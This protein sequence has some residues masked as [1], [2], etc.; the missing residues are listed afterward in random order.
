MILESI[1]IRTPCCKRLAMRTV[2]TVLHLGDGMSAKVSANLAQQTVCP[3][4]GSTVAWDEG[5]RLQGFHGQ[6]QTYVFAGLPELE[7]HCR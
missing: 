4:C 3:H 7:H 5:L 2:M 6:M 1:P